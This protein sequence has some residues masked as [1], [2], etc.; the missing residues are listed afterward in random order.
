[1]IP[2]ASRAIAAPSP[3]Q[4]GISDSGTGNSEAG[5]YDRDLS[6]YGGA[7]SG[8]VGGGCEGRENLGG[9]PGSLRCRA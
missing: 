7:S 3:L 1:V 5:A 4:G 6:G 2:G 8:E 9:L